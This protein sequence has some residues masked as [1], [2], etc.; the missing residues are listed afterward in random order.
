MPSGDLFDLPQLSLTFVTDGW[1]VVA[2]VEQVFWG[3]TESRHLVDVIN[4]TDSAHDLDEESKLGQP[5]LALS[6]QRDWGLLTMYALRGF[7]ERTFPGAEGRLRGPLPVDD[8][9]SRYESSDGDRHLDWALRYSHY[10][11]DWD[12]GAHVFRGTGREPSLIPDPQ[13]NVLR[14]FYQQITQA[15]VDI[16]Y[17]R[18]AWLWKLEGLVREGQGR[19]FC[20][21]CRGIRG[22]PLSGG[23]QRR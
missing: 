6:S 17:T 16:Q 12:I 5:M 19:T 13:A 4:Q 15:G 8:S 22:D 14:P 18:E 20:R 11:G 7:R 3:V 1:E 21:C 10:V 23:R 9:I 2:G